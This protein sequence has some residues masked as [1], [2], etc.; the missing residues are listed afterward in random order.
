MLT[1]FHF[2][3]EC[4]VQSFKPLNGL[5]QFFLSCILL[6][7]PGLSWATAKDWGIGFYTGQYYDS[8]PG[9]IIQG[10]GNYLN[11]YMVALTMSKRVWRAKEWPLSMEIDGM[12]GHQFG[13]AT[14]QEFAIAPVARWSGFPWSRVLPTSFR[15]APLGYS[16]TS[17]V[18]P[19]E[20]GPSGDGSRQLNFLILELAFSSPKAKDHEVF[21]RLHHRSSIYGLLN[22]FG[23][24]GQDYT[25]LG[26]RRFF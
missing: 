16:F 9:F 26:Y 1:R 5:I 20:R 25:S 11:Q 15:A 24:N 17:V 23:A 19:L 21:L 2:S 18:S 3:S 13:P 14:L 12:V 10:Q 7:L 22:T 8:E 4:A 6:M